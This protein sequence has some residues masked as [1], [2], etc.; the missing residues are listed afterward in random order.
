MELAHLESVFPHPIL[1]QC[2]WS[3]QL[4]AGAILMTLLCFDVLRKKAGVVFVEKVD[5]AAEEL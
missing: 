5:T 1:R 2:G 3:L 4:Y